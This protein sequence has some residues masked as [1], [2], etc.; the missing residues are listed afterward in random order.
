MA[1]YRAA[2]DLKMNATGRNTSMSVTLDVLKQMEA[3][4][5]DLEKRLGIKFTRTQVL[6]HLI[7]IYR[8]DP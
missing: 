2:R 8:K 1:R 4:G 3:I 6:Q 7:S 5:D